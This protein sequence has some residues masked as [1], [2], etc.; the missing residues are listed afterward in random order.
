M[1]LFQT[2]SRKEWGCCGKEAGPLEVAEV[3]EF[4]IYQG[5]YQNL[6]NH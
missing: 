1:H 2:R 5:S 6:L 4:G 3:T